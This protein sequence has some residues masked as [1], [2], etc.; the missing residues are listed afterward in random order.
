MSEKYKQEQDLLKTLKIKDIEKELPFFFTQFMISI[1]NSKSV[2]TQLNYARRIYLFLK[3]LTTE[4]EFSKGKSIKEL[5]SEDLESVTFQDADMYAYFIKTH[6]LNSNGTFYLKNSKPTTINA[7]ISAVS[8]LYK[9]LYRLNIVNNNPFEGIERAKI[10][11]EPK[12]RLD[13][14]D[15]ELFFSTLKNG[16]GL[17]KHM[18]DYRETNNTVLRDICICSILNS[19]GIRVSELVGLDVSD[20]DLERCRFCVIRK[21]GKTEY[22]YFSDNLKEIIEEY[23]E[24]RPLFHPSENDDALFLRTQGMKYDRDN[25]G[26]FT[27]NISDDKRISVRSIQRIVKKYAVASAIVDSSKFTT[28]KFRHTYAT[29]MLKATGN[30]ALVKKELGHTSIQSTTVYAEADDT[31]KKNARNI[32]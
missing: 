15:S 9:R 24:I 26:N 18:N 32:L 23:L 2:N 22:V 31:D 30:L 13:E 6:S 25:E 16:N 20:I 19:T 17:S 27:E 4:H 28:H 3:W 29:N 7:Y 10:N 12:I 5:S 14:I 11:E 21:G 8:S 1:Q